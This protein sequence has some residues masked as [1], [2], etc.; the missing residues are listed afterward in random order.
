LT[1]NV[2]QSG[3]FFINYFNETLSFVTV[4]YQSTYTIK[5]IFTR[6]VQYLSVK[7]SKLYYVYYF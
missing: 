3:T 4:T 7:N 5:I 2:Q 6:Y 1:S